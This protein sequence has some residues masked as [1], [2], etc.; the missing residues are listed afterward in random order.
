MPEKEEAIQLE[1]IS[2]LKVKKLKDQIYEKIGGDIRPDR[3]KLTIEGGD[4]LD[5]A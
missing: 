4:T 5:R 3:M 1:V 2:S